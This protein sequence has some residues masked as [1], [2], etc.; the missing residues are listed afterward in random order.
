MGTTVQL[1]H[2]THRVPKRVE[3]F[4]DGI[5]VA[6]DGL[7]SIESHKLSH[8]RAAYFRGYQRTPDGRWLSGFADLDRY[9]DS[10]SA[11]SAEEDGREPKKSP[12]R[13]RQSAT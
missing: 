11:E 7:I 9:V 5:A 1:Q 6:R 2:M 4:Y 13:R 12:V 8:L 10:L 3:T